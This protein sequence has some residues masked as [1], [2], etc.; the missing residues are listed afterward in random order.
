LS[1]KQLEILS[2]A[3]KMVK[4]G[5]HLIYSTCSILR[6]EDENVVEQFLA[7]HSDFVIEPVGKL[8]KEAHVPLEMGDYLKLLPNV[9]HTDGFFT[10]VMKRM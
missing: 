4:S 9:H 6:E 7:S 2:A 3:S 8:L 5:G 10:A 1:A